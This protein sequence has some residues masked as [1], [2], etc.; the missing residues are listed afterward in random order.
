MST[1]SGAGL[2]RRPVRIA[3]IG[4]GFGG[5]AAAISLDA[6]GH[7][8]IVVF[9]KAPDVGGTWQANTYPGAACDAP[10]HIY[11]FSFQQDVEWSRRFAPGPEIQRYL[12]DC[13]DR[14]RLRDRIRTGVEVIH[15]RWA[16]EEWVLEL[17][18]GSSHSCDVVVLATGQLSAPSVPDWAH[19]RTFTGPAFH[20][21]R[22][23]HDVD[24]TGKRVAVI[25]TGASAV[26]AIPEIADLASHVT[27]F[28][29]S[30]AY[31]MRKPDSDY[32]SLTHAVYRRFPVLKR[33]ARGA[34]WQGFEWFNTFFWRSPERMDRVQKVFASQLR[35][36]V[37]DPDLRDRLTPDYRIGCKRIAISNDY[38]PALVRP[39]VDVVTAPVRG[40]TETA[41]VTDDGAVDVDV[42]V[43]ATGFRTSEFMSGVE[44]TGTDGSLRNR[45][46]THGASA[47]L[48]VTV[49]TFPNLF[50]IYGPN[51][52]LGAGSI[53]YMME[54]QAAHIVG[55]VDRLARDAVAVEVT[56]AAHRDFVESIR[57]VQ[58]KTVWAGCRNWYVD[59]H[60]RDTHNW[61]AS[62]RDYRR[63]VARFDE[64]AYRITP[65]HASS[66]GR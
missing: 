33:L 49:P 4:A 42:I 30:P 43:Y 48:G 14:Y 55:A 56:D 8:D 31:V 21:A 60:G 44:I 58:H 35:A 37:P 39:H 18:D 63:R 13:V 16:G 34:I 65:A 25:G 62:M 38:Y 17:A 66:V 61:H 27:V 24:L 52:N 46:D 3:V 1:T 5:L 28:Q 54:N 57:R 59:E 12:A 22:W 29:R 51:T 6:A 23:R 32:G 53:L 2:A 41:V 36:Q 11:S 10:S 9:E 20:T 40:L 50:L 26:Q 45:W 19:E 7:R 64:S 15:S 47:Y